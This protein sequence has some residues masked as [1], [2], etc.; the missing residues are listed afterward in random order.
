VAKWQRAGRPRELEGIRRFSLGAKG[1]ELAGQ[2][3]QSNALS[4]QCLL[5]RAPKQICPTKGVSSEV[6]KLEARVTGS[7]KQRETGNH[8]R[9]CRRLLAGEPHI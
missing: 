2:T 1:R 6:Y 9:S 5:K 4:R 3:E 8:E 7:G